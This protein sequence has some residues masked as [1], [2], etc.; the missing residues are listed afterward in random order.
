MQLTYTRP[1]FVKALVEAGLDEPTRARIVEQV[2][3]KG[4]CQDIQEVPEHIRR[5][6]VVSQDITAEEHVRMQAALQAFVDNSLS[7]CVVGDT[8]VLTASG[9]SPISDL[10]DTRL[11][12]QF[13]PVE[14]EV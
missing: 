3:L 1:L 10:S 7:K 2:L 8:L 4:S 11:L 14:L 9:L 13:Q 5:V 6:F 12:D